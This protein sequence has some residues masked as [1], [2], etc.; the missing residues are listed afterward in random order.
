VTHL[1]ADDLKDGHILEVG[2]YNVNGSIRPFFQ[3]SYIKE[4]IGVDLTKGPGVDLVK[5]GH[6]ID[7]PDGYF[8]ATVSCECFEHNPYWLPTF[9]NMIRMTKPGGLIIF[10]CASAGR[11]EHGTKR[12][13]SLDSPGTNI[14]GIDYYK[15]LNRC[16]FEQ[17]VIFA[18]YFKEY[19]FFNIKSSHDLYFIGIK[20]GASEAKNHPWKTLEEEVAS[21]GHMDKMN[22][23][24]LFYRL[25]LDILY[26]ILNEGQYQTAGLTFTRAYTKIRKAIRH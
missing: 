17:N 4:Y 20:K 12:S 6:E 25:P 5:S 16:D 7:Y 1:F 8:N 19:R 14:T 15:N 24:Y 3:A 21:I 18:D 11:L 13:I 22:L 26:K 2:S 9:M 23:G 10:T